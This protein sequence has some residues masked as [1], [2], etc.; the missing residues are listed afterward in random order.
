M[1]FKA[2]AIEYHAI[3]SK[4]GGW[5][6]THAAQWLRTLEKRVFPRVGPLP[7][8]DVS[9]P[10]LLDALRKVEAIGIVRTAHDLREYAE[11]VFRYGVQTGRCTTNPAADLRGAL[12]AF[13]ERNM[14]A[15]LE[16][17]AAGELLRAIAAY[18]GQPV[19]RAA[20][21]I[22]GSCSSGPGMCA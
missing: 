16:P 14:G 21:E 6:A 17:A 15:V 7:L 22:S 18:T 4:S 19:T 13:V 9:A 10:T 11:Q 12:S 3:K 8:A 5:S 20:L 2:V 1:T